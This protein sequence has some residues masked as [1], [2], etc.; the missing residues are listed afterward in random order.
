MRSKF[1]NFIHNVIGGIYHKHQNI[2]NSIFRRACARTLFLVVH[3][4]LL[5]R[6]LLD[7]T[8]KRNYLP[9]KRKKGMKRNQLL[10]L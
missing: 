4:A 5:L 6:Q 9:T 7:H 1:I 10:N 3:G 8:R 2:C